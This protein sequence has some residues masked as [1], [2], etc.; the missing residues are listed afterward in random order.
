MSNPHPH[1]GVVPAATLPHDPLEGTLVWE[2][3]IARV[4]LSGRLDATSVAGAWPTVV[5]PLS[6]GQLSEIRVDARG[7]TYCDGAGIGLLLEIE[8]FAKA[9]GV[10]VM[11]DGLAPGVRELLARATPTSP[12][13]GTGPKPGFVLMVGIGVRSIAADAVS[14][15]SF[16]G[17]GVRAFAWAVANPLKVRWRDV[18]LVC[19]RAGVN[20][21]PV[22]CLLGFLMGLIIAFQT[23]T[24][25][26]QYGAES[27]MPLMMAFAMIRELGPLTTAII[28]AGRSGSAFAAEIG[29]MKVTEEINALTT[30]GLDP[31]RFLVVPR[32]LAAMLMTPLLANFCTLMGLLGG[33]PTM[34][35]F[36]YSTTFYLDGVRRAVEVGDF[37]QG[38]FKALVFALVVAGV[39]CHRG[40]STGSGPGAVGNS[41]T[42]A[43]VAGIVLIVAVD[44]ILGVMFYYTGI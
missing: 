31:V 28:L 36:G 37:L 24:P 10:A 6:S 17:E 8:L 25:L 4:T 34:W 33:L 16:L 32:V 15:I 26:S 22:T 40:L 11:I 3:T 21:L 35:S 2:G 23:A 43:V 5:T 13:A 44:G 29:T 18:L 42:S 14:L 9:K 30:F 20:A 38:V 7:V 19:E 1:S 12:P 41:T 27:Q 39:G